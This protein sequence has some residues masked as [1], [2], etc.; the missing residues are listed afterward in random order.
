VH[1]YNP[2]IWFAAAQARKL[3]EQAC[4]DAVLLA[5][6]KPSEYAQFLLN[7]AEG[8]RG[9][10]GV[11]DVAMGVMQRSHLHARVVAI[12]DSSR[13]RL[14]VDGL[15]LFA[16]LVPLSCLMFLLA[17][18]SADSKPAVGTSVAAQ[19]LDP[20]PIPAIPAIPALPA[21]PATPAIPATLATTSRPATLPIQFL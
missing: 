13:P 8:S 15:A 16:A 17:T 19:T 2:V 20:L 3:Q 5:G 6:G 12:L 1:W 18:A 9:G 11:F 10:S 21:T 7:V 4:D 14:P